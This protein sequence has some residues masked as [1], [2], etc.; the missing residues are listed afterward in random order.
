MPILLMRATATRHRRRSY[1]RQSKFTFNRFSITVHGQ[2]RALPYNPRIGSCI[3]A[4]EFFIIV[5]AIN[6]LID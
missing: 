6:S 5:K 4:Q 2:Y 1:L 3:F